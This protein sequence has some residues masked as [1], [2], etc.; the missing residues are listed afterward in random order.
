MTNQPDQKGAVWICFPSG[1]AFHNRENAE[2]R[3][4]TVRRF[5][6]EAALKTEQKLRANW[7]ESAGDWR[8]LSTN[9]EFARRA[10]ER[11]LKELQEALLRTPAVAAARKAME[12]NGA[13][14]SIEDAFE[15]IHDA[16][17]QLDE[18]KGCGGSGWV[19]DKRGTSVPPN[20]PQEGNFQ[21]P[22][23][24]DCQSQDNREAAR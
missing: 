5:V 17:R 2:E 13:T 8:I 19:K 21:C 24:P 1:I 23:C 10:A 9:E 15:G 18:G 20:P 3:G 22:G 11:D 6:S 4:E 14:V 7:E 16:L 12:E